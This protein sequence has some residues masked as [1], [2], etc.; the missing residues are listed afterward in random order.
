MRRHQAFGT[1]FLIAGLSACTA[2]EINGRDARPTQPPAPADAASPPPQMASFSRLVG[3]EWQV[4]FA[5]GE[6]AFHAWHWGPGKYSLR[7]MAHSSDAVANPWA[8]EVMYWHPGR[9]EVRQLSMHGDIPGVG[10]GVGEGSMRFDG[11]TA[12]GVLDLYQP[13]HLRKLGTRWVFDGPDRYHSTLLEDTG[14]GLKPMNEWNFVRITERPESRPATVEEAT[15][16]LS[17]PLKAFEP[18]LDHIWEAKGEFQDDS[19]AGKAFDIQSTFEWV[20]ALEVICARTIALGSEVEPVHVLDAYV[21]THVKTGTVR[22]LALSNCGNVYEG[23]VTVLESG[24]LQVELQGY[25]GDRV[26]QLVVHFD[27]ENG[28]LHQRVWSIHGAD[29]KLMLD[30]HHRTINRKKD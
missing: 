17:K 7:M 22:C 21:Y 4:T 29:R 12:E 13:R 25:E 6:S 20:A 11:E 19:A 1:L 28:R 8:G 3:G 30:C 15:R 27:F 5:S 24:A 23:D 2:T 10:R 9:K 14:A 16:E 26:V 18:L